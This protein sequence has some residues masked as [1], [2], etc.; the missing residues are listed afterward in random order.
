MARQSLPVER[1]RA[2][3]SSRDVRASFSDSS[4]QTSATLLV[5][6]IRRRALDSP[7]VYPGKDPGAVVVTNRGY[8]AF[9][10]PLDRSRTS[11]CQVERIRAGSEETLDSGADLDCRSLKV[12][13]SNLTWTK[14]GILYTRRLD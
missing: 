6:N 1:S 10:V 5:G 8:F 3:W 12:A 13:G 14:A 9:T 7:R 2:T 4:G 11:G